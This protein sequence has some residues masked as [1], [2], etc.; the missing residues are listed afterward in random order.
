MACPRIDSPNM[1][2]IELLDLGVVWSAAPELLTAGRGLRRT[3]G[4]RAH[5]RSNR[6]RRTVP[7]ASQALCAAPPHRSPGR[8]TRRAREKTTRGKEAPAQKPATGSSM[9][10]NCTPH[11]HSNVMV[12]ALCR[13]K[14]GRWVIYI[15]AGS[16]GGGR[17]A[18]TTPPPLAEGDGGPKVLVGP[19]PPPPPPP[20]PHMS[21]F[22]SLPSSGRP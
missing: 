15:G 7:L 4:V 13:S 19:P 12:W 18:N 6:R 1:G 2:G 17:V 20:S 14:R 11:P 3:A 5:G 9:A 8:A 21:L 22:H 10:T 16:D